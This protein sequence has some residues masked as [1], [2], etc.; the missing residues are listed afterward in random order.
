MRARTARVAWALAAVFGLLAPGTS[1]GQETRAEVIAREKARKAQELRPY[2]PGRAE[3]LVTRVGQGLVELPRGLYPAFGSVYPG[4][5]FALGPAVRVF[6]GDESFFEAKALMSFR[7]YKR[8]EASSIWPALARGR[9]AV[10]ADVGWLD[11]TQVGYFGLGMET[12]ADGGANFRMKET[13]AGVEAR[14]RT[15]GPLVFGSALAYEKYDLSGGRGVRPPIQDRFTPD[16]APG[17]GSDPRFLHAAASAAIDTRP[18][19]GYARRGS[20]LQVDYHAYRDRDE[21]FSFNRVD[22][23]AIQHVP[24]FRENWV[25]SL[26]GL[27][28]STTNDNDQVPFFL[29]PSLGSG[30]TLRG[31][32]TGRFRGR[33]AL[34][35]Q[36][37]WR[38]IVNRSGMDMALFYDAGKVADRRA[39]LD[40]DGLKG[41]VGIGVRFHGPAMTPLRLELARGRE[42]FNLVFAGGAS[43]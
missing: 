9:V 10:R 42:G 29:L 4:G 19:A 11:A 33:H 12:S 22:G 35:L 2:E 21:T 3:R 40:F 23:M 36:A 6:H 25:L 7:Q 34:L 41:N 43:F 38:W 8:I 20:V 31:Y 32:S 14:V 24:I 28:Q 39:G 15:A 18:A 16:T 26:R 5:G 17:L 1:A 37:E 30:S 27:V 13:Y